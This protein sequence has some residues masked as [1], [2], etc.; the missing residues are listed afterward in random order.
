MSGVLPQNC[1]I[2]LL[3]TWYET[4]DYEDELWPPIFHAFRGDCY[5]L[6][7]SLCRF[8]KTG[9]TK[10]VPNLLPNHNCFTSDCNHT[11]LFSRGTDDERT[12]VCSFAHDI[13]TIFFHEIGS[14]SQ[15]KILNF[16]SRLA[17]ALPSNLLGIR[18]ILV[19]LKSL[20]ALD[21]DLSVVLQL[22]L[23]NQLL[24]HQVLDADYDDEEPDDKRRKMEEAK[25][26]WICE[27]DRVHLFLSYRPIVTK[28][29]T[30]QRLTLFP[31]S[32]CFPND[33]EWTVLP[34]QDE[35]SWIFPDRSPALVTYFR[36]SSFNNPNGDDLLLMPYQWDSNLCE[37]SRAWREIRH[38]GAKTLVFDR[39]PFFPDDNFG[40]LSSSFAYVKQKV[41]CCFS[42][43]TSLVV[44]NSL[45]PDQSCP[46][47]ENYLPSTGGDQFLWLDD[48]DSNVV[49][50][51]NDAIFKYHTR[52]MTEADR[53]GER[54]ASEIL[55]KIASFENSREVLESFLASFLER[56]RI[57]SIHR[58]KLFVSPKRKVEPNENFSKQ[59]RKK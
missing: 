58:E 23:P 25:I 52:P 2:Q 44:E 16:A 19:G 36:P 41:L 46:H 33:V 11:H 53:R 51:Y 3:A 22:N 38:D 29:V 10:E 9:H 45:D 14:S 18:W 56:E 21:Q 27:N 26:A 39:L 32:L 48:S 1:S 30:W 8:S 37:H 13:P 4:R 31:K 6:R 12:R 59:K 24:P 47:S 34:G 7:D 50:I 35:G 55:E 43:E 28:K 57:R 5:I 15:P 17:T 49:W 40:L 42:H 54:L 20:V